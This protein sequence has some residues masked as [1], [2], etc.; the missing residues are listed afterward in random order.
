MEHSAHS[1]PELD[2]LEQDDALLKRLTKDFERLQKQKARRIGGVEARV[3]TSLAFAWGEQYIDQAEA[4]LVI[5]PHDDRKLYLT[6]NMIDPRMHK[7]IG[8]LSSVAPVFKARPNSKD[9]L[10]MSEAEVVDR[11]DRGLDERLDQP[12]RVWEIWEWMAQGGVAVV[13]TPWVPDATLESMPQF[14]EDGQLLFRHMPSDRIVPASERDALIAAGEPEEAFEIHEEV[15]SVGEVGCEVYGPLNVFVDQNVKSL[16]SLAPDQ[17]VHLANIKTMG[18]I[19]E[20]FGPQSWDAEKELKIVT[21][22][23]LHEGDASASMFLKDLIPTVQGV[24]QEDDPPMAV[25]VQ[26]FLPASKKHPHGKFAIWVPGKAILFVGENPYDEIPL[27]DFHW[28]P[29]T[30]TFWTK[31]YVTD[32]IAPQ[33]FVNKR[34]SQLGEQSNAAIYDNLLLGGSLTEKDI[35]ADYPGMVKGGVTEQG[36]PLVQ[37]LGGP[38]MPSWFLESI[39]MVVKFLNDI[40]GGSDLF[41]ESRFPGQLRGP[42]AVPMLQEIL[43]TEW[44]P[45]Y[46]HFGQRMAK[47]KQQRLNRVKQFYPPIR[48]LHYTDSDQRDEVLE[49]HADRV[50]RTGTTYNVTVERGS[51]MPEMRALAEDRLLRRLTSPLAVVYQDDRTGGLD[52]AKIAQE[53]KLGEFARES[54]E[55]QARKLSRQLIERLR[56]GEGVP[57]VLS[58]WDHGPML[59]ELEAVMTTTEF[60][61]SSAQFMKAMIERR[62]QHLAFLQQ[63]ADR[64]QQAMQQQAVNSAVMQAAQ[65]A[66]AQA[67]AETVDAVKSMFQDYAQKLAG[68]PPDAA[69]QGYP[70]P[71][72]E[73]GQ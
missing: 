32:L 47:V 27:V 65:Q 44:G 46:H 67:A 54:R 45:L 56:R 3:L 33:R 16:D 57:P 60:L 20:T 40:A 53:L 24:Q 7:L 10:A 11:L 34:L 49:F 17:W 69:R 66:A 63:Q 52:K 37:R 35:P 18:W 13:Y 48:T 9:P 39:N 31:D 72:R 14:S 59:D 64:Q 30:T 19:E 71:R 6:F 42:L 21:T 73:A 8:R 26:S 51:V 43:D 36:V 15:E 23:L 29:V 1:L 70:L 4:G 25:V 62:D 28:G 55:H 61:S 41:Q 5:S 38:Q 50:M 68:G 2:R 22:Q 58:F 12:S